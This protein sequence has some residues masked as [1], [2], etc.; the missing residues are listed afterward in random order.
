MADSRGD[1]P[2]AATKWGKR[3]TADSWDDGR[4]ERRGRPRRGAGDWRRTALYDTRRAVARRKLVRLGDNW[5]SFWL[6][7]G[8]VPGN[9]EGSRPPNP[10]PA[11]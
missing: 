9:L 1:V 11:A 10:G 4:A 8:F 5:V 6:F 2:V 3:N 7:Q